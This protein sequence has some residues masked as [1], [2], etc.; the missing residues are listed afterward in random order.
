MNTSA[1]VDVV[2]PTNRSGEFMREA[3]AS[4]FGQSHAHWSY[5]IV[6]NGSPDPAALADAVEAAVGATSDPHHSRSRVTIERIQTRGISA[7]RN[8]GVTQGTGDYVAFLDDDDFWDPDYLEEMVAA[9]EAEPDA[10][11]AYAAGRFVDEAGVPF[12]EW[13]AEPASRA[14]MLRGEQPFPHIPAFVVRRRSAERV[15]WFDESLHR[16]EDMEFMCRLLIEGEFVAVPRVLVHYRRHVGAE[17]VRSDAI[18]VTWEAS[19]RFLSRHILDA[20]DRG[21]SDVAGHLIE[22]R[23]RARRMFAAH[24]AGKVLRAHRTPRELGEV[25]KSIRQAM[26]LDPIGFLASLFG[27]AGGRIRNRV[28]AVTGR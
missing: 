2:T 24:E 8:H 23:R 22:N 19:E 11:A 28:A 14:E 25:W 4:V 20:R 26:T 9:L 21:D 10:V 18:R 6:D 17:T 15:G 3:T 1:V 7:G 5:V 27:Q 16:A 12:G 13:K